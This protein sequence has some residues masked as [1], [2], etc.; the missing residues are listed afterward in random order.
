[1]QRVN[2]FVF[3]ELA[4]KVH[5]LTEIQNEVTYSA[6]WWRW[7]AAREALDEIYRQRPL[8]FTTTVALRLYNAITAVVP[9]GWEEQI[10]KLP[11]NVEGQPPVVEGILPYWQVSEVR[12]AAKEFETVLRNECL[13]M[14]TYFVSKKGTYS[15]DLIENA[16]HHIPEPTRGRLPD[17]TRMD[18]DQ[19]GKCIAFDVPTAAAFHLLRGTE[20]VI[21]KYY[22]LIVPGPKKASPKMRNWGTYIR[23]MK[24]HG[25]DNHA[26]LLL[27]HLRD[28]YRN[29]VLHPE[30]IYTDERVQVLFGICISAVVLLESAVEKLTA[31]SA[32]PLAFPSAGAL[33][34][35]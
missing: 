29:P 31:K 19:A 32:A 13:I 17:Q 2:E 26:M 12:D 23:L 4:V 8:N 24:N 25:G 3:Y 33:V 10:A 9:K 16:H 14:D 15:K 21:K 28:V 7:A 35:P 5:S 34:V 18:F 6:V 27:D 20:A 1:M 22:E 11:R 30:E